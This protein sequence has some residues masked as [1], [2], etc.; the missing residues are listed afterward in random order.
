MH[1]EEEEHN[2][3]KNIDRNTG[4][5]PNDVS[6]VLFLL[7]EAL[8]TFWAERIFIPIYSFGFQILRFPDVKPFESVWRDKTRAATKGGLHCWMMIRDI[9]NP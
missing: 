4:V 2:N 6:I 9:W 5:V 3:M 7:I 8:P 1:K